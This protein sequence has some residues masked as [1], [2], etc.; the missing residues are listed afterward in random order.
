M[1]PLAVSQLFFGKAFAFK[2]NLRGSFGFP[3]L[4]FLDL[5]CWRKV[6]RIW[7][8]FTRS[9]W[10][11][12]GRRRIGGFC[13]ILRTS[14]HSP[15]CLPSSRLGPFPLP[16]A[17]PRMWWCPSRQFHLTAHYAA[18]SSSVSARV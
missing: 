12:F 8:F 15:L 3:R 6:H 17:H 13:I 16:E 9:C 2:R 18:S 4:F 14:P 7:Y 10:P 11:S 5:L 1:L